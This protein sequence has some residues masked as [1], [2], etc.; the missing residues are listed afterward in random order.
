MLTVSD[1]LMATLGRVTTA[2]GCKTYKNIILYSRL[3][4]TVFRDL[5]PSFFHTSILKQ[6]VKLSH[7]NTHVNYYRHGF[8]RFS[9]E[10]I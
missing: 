6:V 7:M 10:I 9:F 8:Y 2:D 4:G 5:M 1:V 3:L